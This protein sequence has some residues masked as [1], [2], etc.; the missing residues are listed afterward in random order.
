[1]IYDV[2]GNGEISALADGQ[3]LVKYFN[4]LR[5][6]DLIS[7]GPAL[8]ATRT[9]ADQIETYIRGIW[10]TLDVGGDG[11]VSYS[12][13]WTIFLYMSGLIG[14]NLMNGIVSGGDIRNT[15]ELITEY[16][17]RMTT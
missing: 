16:L 6:D 15:E 14:E 12:D 2:D 10:W 13:V 8:G 5:G 17:E 3:L 4:G 9:T 1:M 11:E 7:G